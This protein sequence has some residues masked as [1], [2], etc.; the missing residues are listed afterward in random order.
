MQSW[1]IDPTTG[2]YILLNGSPVTTNSLRVPAYIRLKTKRTQ[3][4]YAPDS[5][6][7]SDFYTVQKRPA[8]NANQRF[9]S[10]ATKA[11]QPMVDDGRASQVQADVTAIPNRNSVA[12]DIIVTDANGEVEQVTFNGLT[13]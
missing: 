3:W 6:Y 13:S 10:I 1:D 11:L 8:E 4:L 9:E 2:D 5:Q 12:M 7:G